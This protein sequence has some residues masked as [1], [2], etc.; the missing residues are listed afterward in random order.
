MMF[1][2]RWPDGSQQAFYSPSLVVAEYLEAGAEYPLADFVGRCRESLTIAG[3]R[4]YAKYGMRCA[5]S[6]IS[7][8]T[9]ERAA[10]CHDDGLVRVERFR[11]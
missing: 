10:A 11:T 8:A 6:A 1:E 5:E 4:V 3:D 9:I 2:V 7:L